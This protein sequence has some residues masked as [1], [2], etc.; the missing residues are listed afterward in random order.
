MRACMCGMNDFKKIKAAA[1]A[2]KFKVIKTNKGHWQFISPDK[3]HPIIVTS[4]TYSDRRAIDNF[5][6]RLRKAGF[7]DGRHVKAG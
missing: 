6:A 1:E 4:G 5:V 3:N 2:Q 7:N